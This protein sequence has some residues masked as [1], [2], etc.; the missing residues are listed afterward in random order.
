MG[1]TPSLMFN[2]ANV[3]TRLRYPIG[4]RVLVFTT[5]IDVEY[6][7]ADYTRSIP[8]YWADGYASY[9]QGTGLTFMVEFEDGFL[10]FVEGS[11]VKIMELSPFR[12][13]D[14]NAQNFR[15]TR[16]A[17]PFIET[18]T[19]VYL[20]YPNP[21]GTNYT[22]QIG[23]SKQDGSTAYVEVASSANQALS[24]EVWEANWKVGDPWYM[25]PGFMVRQDL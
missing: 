3:S 20:E 13:A 17:D 14:Y 9:Q 18:I 4:G 23:Y 11:E 21:D 25:R 22:T 7:T 1:V 5:S 8:L 24:Q 2:E 19:S 12:Q 16:P 6:L 10:T 15:I